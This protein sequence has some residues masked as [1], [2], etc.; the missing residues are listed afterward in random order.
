MKNKKL[1]ALL[2]EYAEGTIDPAERNSVEQYLRESEDARE[3]LALLQQTFH[4][5]HTDAPITVPTHYFTN[6]LG[7][8]HSQLEDRKYRWESWLPSWSYL[9]AAPLTAIAI[10]GSMVALFVLMK[11]DVGNS[12]MYSIIDQA[13]QE[14]MFDVTLSSPGSVVRQS[15]ESPLSL[16]TTESD[17]NRSVL[18]GELLASNTL[19]E[20]IVTDNQILSQLNEQDI[21]MVM[22]YFNERDVQ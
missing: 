3:D 16:L 18:A 19:Y 9:I 13:Q 10:I 12:Q 20:N 8:L 6:F 1:H 17:I 11:N 21:D 2:I 22:N 15:T 5:L 4:R 7:K 14:E